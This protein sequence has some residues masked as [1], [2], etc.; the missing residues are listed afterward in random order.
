MLEGSSI[1]T[2]FNMLQIFIKSLLRCHK[3]QVSQLWLRPFLESTSLQ[4]SQ[5]HRQTKQATAWQQAGCR[6]RISSQGG[7][8][9]QFWKV[10]WGEV[11][12]V[13]GALKYNLQNHASPESRV[14]V[15]LL[16]SS[17]ITKQGQEGPIRKDFSLVIFYRLLALA[18][19]G[20]CIFKV[21]KIRFRIFL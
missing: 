7:S 6:H 13:K 17:L 20:I 3:C 9:P 2:G 14:K 18:T 1:L 4:P 21:T 10:K 19:I 12:L 15:H 5:G 11:W 8:Q 16:M